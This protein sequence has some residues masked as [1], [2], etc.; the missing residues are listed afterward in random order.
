M[1][2]QEKLDN[3]KDKLKNIQRML[4]YE[5]DSQIKYLQ[6]QEKQIKLESKIKELEKQLINSLKKYWI[7]IGNGWKKRIN[8]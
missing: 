3:K 7:D 1:N 6:Y 8:K 4:E 5:I 2:T